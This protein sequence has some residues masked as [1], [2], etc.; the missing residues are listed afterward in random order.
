M[1][2]YKVIILGAPGVGKTSL[3]QRYI[4]DIF[5][6]QVPQQSLQEEDKIV[7]IGNRQVKLKICDMAGQDVV[8]LMTK[9]FYSGTHAVIYVYDVTN[10][11]S[12]FDADTWL[13]DLEIYLTQDLHN[14]IPILFVGNKSDRIPEV[15]EQRVQQPSPSGLTT[16][17]LA[18]KGIN[19]QDALAWGSRETDDAEQ[20]KVEIVTLKRVESFLRALKGKKPNLIFLHPAECSALSGRG[21]TEVFT[22]I[23]MFL[24]SDRGAQRGR[25]KCNIL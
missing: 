11:Q 4:H 1:D 14:G 6:V 19:E 5:D 9:Q 15:Q 13:K 7:N 17:Q 16:A 22:M 2:E 23:S 20:E 24:V 10:D 21:V 3:I 18:K 12:L 25:F 8:D